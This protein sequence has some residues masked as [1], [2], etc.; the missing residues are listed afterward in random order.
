MIPIPSPQDNNTLKFSLWEDTTIAAAVE[1]DRKKFNDLE[2]YCLIMPRL[3]RDQYLSLNLISDIFLDTIDWSGGNTTLEAIACN[4]PVVTLP[5]QFMRSRHSYAMLTIL[6]T[7]ETIAQS[8]S[9]YIDIA[10]KLGLDRSW[11]SQIVQKMQAH[12]DRLYNDRICLQA[13]EEFFSNPAAY[14][15]NHIKEHDQF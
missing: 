14:R 11:R 12:S 4:L 9:E 1:I 7:T 3:E 5:K 13:L 8:E 2:D 10:V 15:A 6:E